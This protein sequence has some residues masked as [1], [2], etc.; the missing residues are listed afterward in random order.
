[1]GPLTL[2]HHNGGGE[3]LLKSVIAPRVNYE[4]VGRPSSH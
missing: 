4:R 2:R 3:D 1:M